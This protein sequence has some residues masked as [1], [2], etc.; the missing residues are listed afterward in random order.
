VAGGAGAALLEVDGEPVIET[1]VRREEA[2]ALGLDHPNAGDLVVFMK[3][4]FVATSRIGGALHEPNPYAGQHG[5]RN[6]HPEVAG[7]WLARGAGV[8]Q[9]R[10]AE[11]PL[12]G[13]AAFV[14][15]LAG[16][17]PPAQAQR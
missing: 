1:M 16:V 6:V 10:R 11:A 4:G 8:V 15:A 14:A 17:E 3:P 12:T 7:V 13:V 9:A 5:Y 2:A